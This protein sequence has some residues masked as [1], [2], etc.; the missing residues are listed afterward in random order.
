MTDYVDRGI[1]FN[2]RFEVLRSELEKR[3][4]GL[5]CMWQAT[6]DTSFKYPDVEG[7]VVRSLGGGKPAI[8]TIVVKDY[9]ENGI[10]VWTEDP[11]S[12]IAK[13][14]ERIVG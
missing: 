13:T 7:Y 3:G 14:V 10:G 2:A 8:A 4:F 5:W 11:F 1:P 12:E 6:C 9:G